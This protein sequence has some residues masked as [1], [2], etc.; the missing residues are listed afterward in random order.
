MRRIAVD[1]GCGFGESIAGLF[2]LEPRSVKIGGR[3]VFRNNAG[4]TATHYVFDKTV[5][6]HRF[7]FD[8]DEECAFAS[9]SRI[10]RYVQRDRRSIAKKLGVKLLCDTAGCKFC[11]AQYGLVPY[12]RELYDSG[13]IPANIPQMISYKLA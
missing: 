10:V 8:R 7:A 11:C 4:G 3:I 5:A 13:K 1:D 12:E 9:L 2:Y 6:V